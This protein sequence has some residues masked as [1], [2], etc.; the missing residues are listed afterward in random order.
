MPLKVRVRPD[1][2]SLEVAGRIKL[3]D[4]SKLRVRFR[5]QSTDRKLAEEEAIAYQAQV[6]REAWHGKK[7]GS[8]SF[9]E[10]VGSYINS[11]PRSPSEQA[12]LKRIMLALGDVTLAEVD[13]Q[14]V[15]RVCAKALRPGAKPATRTRE[16]IGPIRTV[17]NHAH[18]QKEKDGSRWCDAPTFEIPEGS[19]GRTL[20]LTPAEARALVEAA[21]PHLKPLLLFLIG[22]GARLGE[23][24]EL[25]WT[26]VDLD[27]ATARLLKTKNGKQRVV[28]LPPV[29]AAALRSLLRQKKGYVFL[30]Q[31]G[32]PYEDRER[33]AGG[34]IRSAFEGA[35][36]RAELN[37]AYSPHCLRHTFASWHWAIHKDDLRLMKAGGWSS[38]KLVERYAHLLP[39]KHVPEMI[40]FLK[41]DWKRQEIAAP[42]Q[43]DQRTTE[44]LAEND[45]RTTEYLAENDQRTTE[46]LAEN[47]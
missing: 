2:G 32:V 36:R 38:L 14:A 46:Y 30:T 7:Q 9:A 22:T 29:V 39:V 4:G 42:A 13:Q 40:E 34:Q 12:R 26:E 31:R 17:L 28:E 15:N 43:N 45:Q 27:G 33:Q 44:Y 19:P 41:G 3:P 6:L 37:P 18:R 47:G 16:V 21:A 8:R 23:A 5:P 35:V 1:T 25:E 10:A 24:L 20:F 11:K